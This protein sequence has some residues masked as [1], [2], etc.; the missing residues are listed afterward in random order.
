MKTFIDREDK[1]IEKSLLGIYTTSKRSLV[2]IIEGCYKV[3]N[4]Q[5]NNDLNDFG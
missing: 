1:Y 5:L 4:H 2:T 3:P